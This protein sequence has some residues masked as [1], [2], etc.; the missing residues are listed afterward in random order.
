MDKSKKLKC[1]VWAGAAVIP[2]I[3]SAP[4]H[5]LY[6]L[7][8]CP[9]IAVFSPVNESVGEHAK[10]ILY[11]I[12]ISSCTLY[13]VLRRPRNLRADKYFASAL[14]YALSAEYAMVTLYYLVFCGFGL[15]DKLPYHIA[16]EVVSVAIGLSIGC[17]IY[18]NGNPKYGLPVSI[19]LLAITVALMT[20]FTF[21]PAPIPLYATT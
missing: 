1:A 21:V 12:L 5:F 8:G 18:K 11:P 15:A 17:H 20:V 7:T 2:I 14:S 4:L 10:I 9:F 6:S 13:A 16:L 3:I 19:A